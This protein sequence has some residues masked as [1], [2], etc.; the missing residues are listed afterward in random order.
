ML[1]EVGGDFE[2][3]VVP[4]LGRWAVV[5]YEKPGKSVLAEDLFPT[6]GLAVARARDFEGLL[7][8]GRKA[9]GLSPARP[10]GRR[11]GFPSGRGRAHPP[12]QG[13]AAAVPRTWSPV[14]RVRS[15]VRSGAPTP[16]RGR[17][18]FPGPH[19]RRAGGW[20]H[21]A[22]RSGRGS[23]MRHPMSTPKVCSL[24]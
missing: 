12:G 14:F 8:Q 22:R 2:I 13:S 11:V 24:V 9:G 19:R 23:A 20:R 6:R 17:G 21:P 1:I 16:A 15:S 18:P 3:E 5:V 10:R 7:R 4:A